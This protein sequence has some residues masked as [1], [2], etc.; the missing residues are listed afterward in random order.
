MRDDPI[1]EEV[2]AV[3]AAHC[4]RLG[5]DLRAIYDDLKRQEGASGRKFVSYP[6]RRVSAAAVH[7]PVADEARG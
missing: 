3:R 5:F 7:R 6:P 4:A 1:V 2:R